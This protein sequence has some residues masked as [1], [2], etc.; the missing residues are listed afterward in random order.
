MT[1]LQHQAEL[2]Q[3]LR[4]IGAEPVALCSGNIP[5]TRYETCAFDRG[6][7]PLADTDAFIYPRIRISSHAAG[8]GGSLIGLRATRGLIS[9]EAA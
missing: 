4:Q 2:H 1:R 9:I 7:K 6:D 3:I 5:Y 8:Y